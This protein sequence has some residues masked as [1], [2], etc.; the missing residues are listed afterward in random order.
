MSQLTTAVPEPERDALESI[1][2]KDESR[3]AT[4]LPPSLPTVELA[5]DVDMDPDS[6]DMD[7]DADDVND[8]NVQGAS[9][10]KSPSL[11]VPSDADTAH[12]AVTVAVPDVPEEWINLSFKWSGKAYELRLSASDLWVSSS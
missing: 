4:P 1:N 2:S 12:S 9:A 7:V 3:Q 11:R 8:V 10:P 5:K 6:A